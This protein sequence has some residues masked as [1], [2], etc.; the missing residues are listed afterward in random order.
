MDESS[1]SK[2]NEYHHQRNMTQATSQKVITNAE[3]DQI[4]S[5]LLISTQKRKHTTKRNWNDDETKLLTWAID[6][7]STKRNITA[8][9]FT[10]SDW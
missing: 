3:A 9:N 2:G 5:R 4:Y 1:L 10:N 8:E 6:T 7:Y